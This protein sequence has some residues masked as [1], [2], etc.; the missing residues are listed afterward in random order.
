MY[1]KNI[2]SLN[3]KKKIKLIN[4][5]FVKLYKICSEKEFSYLK[6]LL[7]KDKQFTIKEKNFYFYIHN[8]LINLNGKNYSFDSKR[9]FFTKSN[10]TFNTITNTAIFLFFQ[11]KKETVKIGK[12]KLAKKNKFYIVRNSSIREKYWGQIITLF[13]NSMG[14]C[15]IIFMKNGSQSSMEFHIRKKENYYINY[16]KIDLGIRYGRA[17]QKIIKLTKNC[18]FLM[19]PGTMHMRIAELDTQIIEMSTKDRDDD[20]IIVHDGKKFKFIETRE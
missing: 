19:L 14:A 10:L 4:L 3:T 11:K 1:G 18:S 6:I 8:G 5:N 2:N 12:K 13:S 15:K 7:P 17:K 16:G 9:T 20:S